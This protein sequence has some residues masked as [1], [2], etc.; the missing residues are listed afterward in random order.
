MRWVLVL[1]SIVIGVIAALTTGYWFGLGYALLA[2]L[3]QLML[4]LRPAHRKVSEDSVIQLTGGFCYLDGRRMP[5]RLARWRFEER[6]QLIR[7]LRR[8]QE[9]N[10]SSALGV[11]A[12]QAPGDLPRLGFRLENGR[13][14]SV[15]LDWHH[16]PHTLIVGP[17]G[18]GKSVLLASL[19][20]EIARL[21]P[22]GAPPLLFCDFKSGHS[23]RSNQR[24]ISRWQ[25]GGALDA[26]TNA[27]T[28]ANTKTCTDIDEAVGELAT[29]ISTAEHTAAHDE[30]RLVVVIEELG[31]AMRNPRFAAALA[32]LAATG[33]TAG[34]KIIA[35]NQTAT[36]LPRGTV[37]NFG[38]RVA[39]AGCDPAELMLLG[40]SSNALNSSEKAATDGGPTRK[41]TAEGASVFE[42][43]L[44]NPQIKFRFVA[45]WFGDGF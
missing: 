26:K 17:T 41:I 15:D 25:S 33:R 32:D 31:V 34:V 3:T 40:G 9:E 14:R 20:R 37:V 30:V 12:A 39:M 6:E 19:L 43:K 18:S 13:L 4:M 5:K 10:S 16:Q 23:I 36:G 8:R 21:R 27:A 2:A 42:A 11:A 7:H 29:L 1:P 44:V 38:N 45:D 22:P 24:L 28:S 35:T